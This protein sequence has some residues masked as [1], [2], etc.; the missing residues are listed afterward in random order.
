MADGQISLFRRIFSIQL[1]RKESLLRRN[2]PQF[3]PTYD[4][5]NH[6]KG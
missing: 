1:H 2:S 3:Y 6:V 4:I 5:A